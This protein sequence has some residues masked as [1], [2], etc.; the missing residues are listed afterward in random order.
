M[1]GL[2]NKLKYYFNLV[3]N[4]VYNKLQNLKNHL[5]WRYNIKL[6]YFI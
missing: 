3:L 6:L 4:N 1:Y 5:V 2:K